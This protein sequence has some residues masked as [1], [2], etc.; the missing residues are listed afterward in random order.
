M[1]VVLLASSKCVCRKPKRVARLLL[2]S[3]LLSLIWLPAFSQTTQGTIQGAVVD[4]TGGFVA[5][6]MVSVTDVA[7][8]VTRSLMTDNAG[9]YVATNLTPGTY[10]VRAEAKGFRPVEHTGVLVEV[11]QNIRVDLTVQPGEQTQTITVTGELPSIDTTD[12][13]LGGTVSNQTINALPLNGRNFQRLIQ[14]RPGVVTPVGGGTGAGQSSN[15]RNTQNDMLRLEGIAGI[16]ES[17]GANVLNTAYR[18]GDT[19]SLVPID[20]IQEFSA[21]QNPKAEYGFR[22]GSSV[23]VGVKSGTNSLHGTAY[24]FGRDANATDAGNSFIKALTPNPGAPPIPAV[25]PATLEQFGATAGG[26]IIKDKLFWFASFEGLRV[27]VGDVNVLTMPS[28]VAMTAAADPQSQ[29]SIVDACKALGPAK[30]NAVSAQ[31]A[32][33]NPATCVVTPASSSFENV[34]P[35]VNSATSTS[36][37]PQLTSTGPLN[38][39]LFK[40]DYNIG[41][42]HHLNGMY[43]RSSATQ[44]S[45]TI[46]G[47]TEPQWL[48]TVPQ[49][50]YQYDGDWTWT[51]NST[52]VNDFRL[53]YVYVKNTTF[54]GDIN[55]PAGGTYPNGYSL[56]TGVTEPQYFGFPEIDISGF[57]GMLGAGRRTGTRGPEGNVDLVESVSYLRGK[58]T[59]KFGFEYIDI[60]FDSTSFSQAQGQIQFPDLQTYLQGFTNNW[61]ILL[62][63]VAA[64]TQVVRSHW[65]GAFVQDDW[66]LTPRVTLN[67]G[68]RWDYAGPTQD[69]NGNLSTFNPNVT[70]NT[71]A[72]EQ[73]GPGLPLSRIYNGDYRDFDPRVGVAWDVKGNG[74]TVVRAAGA[75][76]TNMNPV[77]TFDPTNPFGA[78]FPSLGVNTTGTAL[79]A[80]YTSV[81]LGNRCPATST[82]CAGGFNWS[83]NPIFPG[84][85]SFTCSPGA[86]CPVIGVDPNFKEPYSV[87]WNLDVQ[88]AITNALTVDVAYVGN[89]GFRQELNM[90]LNQPVLG[91]GWDGTAVSTCLNPASVPLYKTCKP[92][93]GS[94]V[95]AISAS[96][97]FPYISNIDWAT[98]GYSS[99]YDAL[100]V[101]AQARA[102]HG[103]SF[104]SGYTY[105]HALGENNGSSTQGGGTLP[106]DKNNLRLN[107]GN[108]TTDLRHRFTFSPTYDIPGMK[109]PA[110]MLKGWSL[111]AIL[112]VQSGLAWNPSDT[113]TTDWLGEGENSS[114]GN[115]A[116]VIQYWNY[117][118]PRSAFDNPGSTP[119]PCYNGSNGKLAGCAP[120]A[121][122]PAAVLAA[123]QS[124]ATAPYGGASTTLGQLAIASLTNNGC[125]AQGGGYLTPPAYG[126]SGNAGNGIF[127]GP[128]YRNVD[129]SIGKLWSLKERYSAQFRVEFF[130]LLNRAD[131]AA[132]GSDP[133]KGL[134][135]SFGYAQTTPDSSNPVLGSGGPRHIQFGLK[136]TF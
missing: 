102:Y 56:P 41:P 40:I 23:N 118:G 133:S 61:T 51:P 117:S 63:S 52:L 53:G 83:G 75:R 95:G 7:R 110:Q 86:P 121:N 19:S 113:R 5:G 38:N 103:L 20:A 96:G 10:T 68:L 57:T 122:T 21:Q 67:L 107:Y 37:I 54:P 106:S 116:G 115:A 31:L 81:Q 119:V 55:L 69:L 4:Q 123:C 91:A 1:S 97:K 111:S 13:T 136:L 135:G 92:T 50:A 109:A 32:G 104:L 8:G 33:L 47:Q 29:L 48:A 36:F 24:A 34:F 87:Q 64:N 98:N 28:L 2:V 27:T 126:T 105:S 134:T 108:L 30:I 25:T 82:T 16:A 112:V 94:E 11:G 120:F 35:A 58:H 130:N 62:G 15:G 65:Y 14:L 49:N 9:E 90:D 70:G 12:A 6:A 78:N 99:N 84:S 46:A 43:Y 129:F 101:T 88:R 71:P 45:N 128:V 127:T 114:N 74:K 66:R 76:L 39:G 22:D 17:T 18:A 26:R 125:Y 72:I 60:V 44:T 100:Q 77:T 124:A 59:L 132:P 79:N 42:H 131:F 73:V 89:H 93:G 80:N 85:V 3:A